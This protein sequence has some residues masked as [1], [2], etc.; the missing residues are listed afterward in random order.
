MFIEERRDKIIRLLQKDGRVKVK[1]LSDLFDV[2]D[3]CIRKDLRM[4]EKEGQ[5]KRTYGGAI[6]SKDYP[7][8]RDVVDRKDFNLE[9]KRLIAAKILDT[10][11]DNETIFMDISTTNILAAELLGKSKRR[12]IVVSNMVDILKQLSKNNN[13]TAIGTGGTYVKT[14]NGF[15]GAETMEMVEHYSFDRAFVGTCGLDF[16]DNS[17]TTLGADDGLTKKAIIKS[18]RHRYLIME[19]EKFYFNECYKFAHFDDIEGIITNEFP[20]ETTK[21]ALE[22][23]GVTL[24]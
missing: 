6:L 5:L 2:S 22:S 21:I 19:K 7:L 9:Q 10:I 15:L 3:D 11:Q 8:V 1:E 13:I 4:L 23:A 20:D 17:I 16:T 14:V 18:S 12:M 24:Y